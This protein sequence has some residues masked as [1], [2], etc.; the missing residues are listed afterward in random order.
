MKP[1]FLYFLPL[2]LG[3]TF[4]GYEK[5]NTGT[6]TPAASKADLLTAKE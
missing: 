2:A 3:L 5:D 6:P 4:A 1:R